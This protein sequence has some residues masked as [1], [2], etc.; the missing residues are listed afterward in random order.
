MYYAHSL[1]HDSNPQCWQKL[2]DHLQQVS[3]RAS[4]FAAIFDAQNFGSL[5]GLW[6]DLGKYQNEFQ[7]RLS[8]KNV[9]IEHSGIGA[10][11]SWSKDRELG[12][13][14]AFVIAGHH[15][16]LTNLVESETGLPTPLLT[17]LKNNAQ[18]LATV[19]PNIP[20]SIINPALPELPQFLT[21]TS[22]AS[23]DTL[24]SLR[25]S[26]E[27]WIRFL[28]STLIDADRL[29]T[30]AFLAQETSAIR[31]HFDSIARNRGRLDT[32]IDQ[33]MAALPPQNSKSTVNRARAQ[34]L[35]Q[36]RVQSK[37]KP[38]IFS[39]TV[40]TGGGKTLSAMSFALRHAENHN[41]RRIIVVI[42]YT[43]IIEQNAEV[44]REALGIE[45]VV[46]HHSNIDPLDERQKQDIEITKRYAL[47]AE[48]W[49]APIIVTTS[50]QFFES[51][52][53]NRPTRCRKLHN[54]ARS[55]IILDE[56]QT[57]PPGFL[58]SI[59]D[60][61]NELTTHYGC[62]V[63]L[64]T[65]T[66]PALT[67]RQ[68]L[69]LGL[70]NVHPIIP[71]PQTL[72]QTLSRVD[73]TWP[74]PG[75]PP[76]EWD[77]LAQ[78]IVGHPRVLAIVHRR[79][80]AHV[81]AQII[82]R[83]R[84]QET[85]FHLSALMCPAHRSEILTTIRHTLDQNIPCRVVS[86][87]LVEAGVDLDFPVV[88]RALG[89]LDSMVQAAGRCNREGTQT[90]GR[91]IIFQA[92]T[93]PPPGTL[94]KGQETTLSLLRISGALD[95]NEPELFEHYFRMLYF[96]ESLDIHNIQ[97]HRQ[98]LNFGTVGRDFRLIEDGYTQPVIMPYGT[99][100][101]RLANLGQEGPNR[102][103]LRVLQPFIVNIYP[104][105][106]E[107]L[108]H[109]GALEEV[110]EGLYTLTT[111]FKHLYDAEFGLLLEPEPPLAD[112]SQLIA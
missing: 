109:V 45:N 10:A 1:E 104:Q 28:F 97:T 40:P 8:G 84:P 37:H 49:D 63:V 42:P 56:V 82:R 23:Q 7:E 96:S 14:L 54:I 41:L 6:H 51:L 62:S 93:Q 112:P 99:S 108:F 5:A 105:A 103:N 107:Q 81:L 111:P 102:Q 32:F 100:G 68:T 73:Y 87:Q 88:Y 35:D 80:D 58:N 98:K 90:T 50:V 86:T 4:N 94:R 31:G 53:S 77:T 76:I 91:V 48:N 33:K 74:D 39:L 12:L 52:F 89:G 85:C 66:P 69:P 29:D 59:L 47:A 43:S 3:A 38:G 13:P 64:S 92:P 26:S 16:G 25:R 30:E 75:A 22:N 11:L 65:A 17:R 24:Q 2:E 71:D 83:N 60:A 36:C 9:A 106:F 70:K 110:I 20:E 19:S 95:P 101:A 27:F 55:V 78:K 72:S 21:P 44:Y 46:E 57:L 67:T 79:Q 61:L 34:I 15:T 18:Q